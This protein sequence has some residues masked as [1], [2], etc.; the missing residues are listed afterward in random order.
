MSLNPKIRDWRGQRI[1]LVGASDGIGAALARELHAAGAVLALSARR[2]HALQALNL[3]GALL[4]PCDATDPEAVEAT[5][6]Q[7]LAKWGRIDLACYLAGDYS[8]MPVS[9]INLATMQRLWA[10]NYSG[11]AHLAAALVP[12]ALNG[13]L[14][15]MAFMA[16]VA[17][18][19]GLPKA[20]AY[21]PPKAALI[22][23]AEILHL[24]L[25]PKG[26]GVWVIN[27]GFVSTRLTEQND[28]TMPALISPQEAAHATIAGFASGDFEIDYP[29]RFTRV[30][31]RV[32][33]LPYRWYFSL[34]RRFTG[35]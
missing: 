3:P 32:S 26:V 21:G 23:L 31:R 11:G 17:G 18:Y 9:Q 27:P 7:L 34:V 33:R 35:I 1:W 29:R 14:G 16:S 30:L 22:H 13:Q 12:L 15:G 2:A 4:L 19:R 6:R 24:E 28:F 10:V 8:A 20:L 25:A 5:A